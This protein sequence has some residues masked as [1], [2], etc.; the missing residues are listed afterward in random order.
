MPAQ[1]IPCRK[2]DHCDIRFENPRQCHVSACP[3]YAPDPKA[4]GK[5]KAELLNQVEVVKEGKA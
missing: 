2:V 3:W 1:S 4:E 5:R